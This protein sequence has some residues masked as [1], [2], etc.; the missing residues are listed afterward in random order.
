MGAQSFTQY[1]PHP[2][3]LI[4]FN[5]ARDEAGYEHGHGYS[6]SLA[7]KRTY[8]LLDEPA[9]L[10]SAV[11][12]WAETLLLEDD[13]RWCEKWGP[14]GALPVCAIEGGPIV[15]WLFFGIASS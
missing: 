14:C 12:E 9:G 6:G 1:G 4:A 15:G 2:I 7:E 8:R 5:R 13:P 11:T 3:A 10:L